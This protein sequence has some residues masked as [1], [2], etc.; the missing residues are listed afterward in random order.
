MKTSLFILALFAAATVALAADPTT[1]QL[2]R[3]GP[4]NLRQTNAPP[5]PKI[6]EPK[7][8]PRYDVI[9]LPGTSIIITSTNTFTAT[10]A[11]R[12]LKEA[13]RTLH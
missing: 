13:I 2:R 9:L 12:W 8:G 4:R 7:L 6:E 1:N 3:L 5:V 10:E 11:K